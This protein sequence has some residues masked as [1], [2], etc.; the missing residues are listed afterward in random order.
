MVPSKQNDSQADSDADSPI[1]YQLVVD[2]DRT[3]AGAITAGRYDRVNDF[4]TAENFPTKGSGTVE[5]EAVLINL[6]RP[7]DSQEVKSEMAKRGLRPATIEELLAFGEAYPE[8]QEEFPVTE[9]GSSYVDVFDARQVATLRSDVPYDHLTRDLDRDWDSGDWNPGVHFL[10][11]RK[12]RG[13][14]DDSQVGSD[15]DSSTN[16]P[17]VVDYD[18]TLAE[19]VAAGHYGYVF[20]EINAENFPIVG[21]GTVECEAI[22]VNLGRPA[23]SPKQAEWEMAKCGLRPATVEELLA[24]GEAYPDIQREFFVIALGSIWADP[25][26]RRHVAYLSGNAS[27]RDLYLCGYDNKWDPDDRFLAVRK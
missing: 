19:M 9:L 11:V 12:A 24:F 23:R 26:G 18:R 7:A 8:V 2:Y 22:L 14:T 17:L 16:Y 4:I 5:Y 20:D 10:A 25:N 3:L 6:G 13:K 1:I 21:S 15:A 27:D